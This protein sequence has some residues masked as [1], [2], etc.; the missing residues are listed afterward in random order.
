MPPPGLCSHNIHSIRYKSPVTPEE[1]SEYFAFRWEMLRK[2]LA[3]PRGSEQD[4][5]EGDAFHIAA[6]DEQLIVGVG[7]LHT[8]SGCAARIR[9]MAVHAKYQYQGIGSS[10]LRQLERFAR[11]HRMQVCWLYARENAVKFY[12]GNGYVIHGK[13]RSEL[14]A[15]H[16]ERMEKQLT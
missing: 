4:E 6:Y 13:S 15:L 8:E 14:S 3:L 1:F 5:R 9:Y 2:P 12:T 16:H 10:I 11:S 7:R